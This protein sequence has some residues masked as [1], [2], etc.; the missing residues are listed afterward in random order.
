MAGVIPG[1][2]EAA[3]DENFWDKVLAILSPVFQTD[4]GM[5]VAIDKQREQALYAHA[6]GFDSRSGL[7]SLAR[8]GVEGDFYYQ[9]SRN[10][11]AGSTYRGSDLLAPE[12]RRQA[13]IYQ[14]IAVPLNVEH[15]VGG[16][17]ENDEAMYAAIGFLRPRSL[18]NF[19]A[20]APR[21][22]AMSLEHLRQA[23]R[24]GRRVREAEDIKQLGLEALERSRHGV[25]LLDLAGRA[26]F[27]TREAERIVRADDCLAL[28]H[29]MPRFHAPAVQARYERLLRLSVQVHE[30]RPSW[31][32]RPF[33][34]PRPGPA[35]P[36]EV[37]VVPLVN[38][39]G[40][41]SLPGRVAAMLLVS[42]PL[43]RARIPFEQLAETFD[44]TSAEARLC[45]ELVALGSLQAAA[46][47]CAI[48]I[49]TARSHLKKVFTKLNVRSQAQLVLMLGA[50]LIG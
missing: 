23:V 25:I 12:V 43:E 3:L 22:M 10:L 9:A 13:R 17:V 30:G 42:D 37:L 2:Y 44:L 45:R 35:L 18:G 5:V 14:E 31:A 15:L 48:Q 47:A 50:T 16:L 26:V 20:D 36:Y 40:R 34:V 7:Q 39:A 1:I 24:I 27:V 49:S 29:G 6:A 8:D 32:G 46:D 28:R 33:Q 41:Q 38:R 4:V 19:D 21:A 11:P